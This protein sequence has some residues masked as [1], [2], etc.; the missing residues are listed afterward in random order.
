[1]P[2]SRF[3]SVSKLYGNGAGEVRALDDVTVDVQRGGFTASWGRP[4]RASRRS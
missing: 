1:M 3:H 4:A 2:S